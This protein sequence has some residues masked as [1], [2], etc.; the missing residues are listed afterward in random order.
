MSVLIK[1]ME[2][3]KDCPMCPFAYWDFTEEFRGCKVVNGK[4]YA[5]DTEP[6]YPETN[7]RPS[8]CPLV[9]VPPHGRLIEDT[10]VRE[11]IDEWLDS[12]GDV[13]VGHGL[14]YFGE[15][16]GCIKDAPTIIPADNVLGKEEVEQ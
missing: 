5:M 1:N 10:A 11:Q 2:M 3:P 14:S 15:L 7:F 12:V 6:G 9:P 4:K 13:V 16:L 8:W